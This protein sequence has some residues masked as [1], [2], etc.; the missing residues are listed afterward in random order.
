M[1]EPLKVELLNKPKPF[2]ER[3][4]SYVPIFISV[5]A[6]AVAINGAIEARKH[7]KLSVRPYVRFNH[8]GAANAPK[9]GLNVENNGLGPAVISKFSIFLNKE[10]MEKYGFPDWEGVSDKLSDILD[11]NSTEWFWS[12]DGYVVKAGQSLTL[13][14]IPPEK[15][16]D[17]R[18]F[19]K[20]ISEK[21]IVRLHVC[22]LY[23]EC[24]D[25]C[26]GDISW[27]ECESLK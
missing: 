5:L 10:R 27:D 25:V 11:S 9:V 21:L 3:I 7:N 17:L 23:G 6:L 26:S 24:D 1:R 20:L 22:S 13:Y 16:R 12:S 18:V 8:I 14:M 19:R 4:S 2:L 15:V